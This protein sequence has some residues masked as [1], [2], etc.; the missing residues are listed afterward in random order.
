MKIIADRQ[1]PY[2]QQVFSDL[3]DIIL[4]DGREITSRRLRNADVLL[5][6]SVTRVNADL[7][8]GSRIRFVASA[9]SGIDHVDLEHLEQLQIG[10]AFAPGSNARSVVEYVLSSLFVLASQENILLR[11]KVIGIIGCGQIGS[12]LLESLG[13][14]GIKCLVNDPPLRDKTGDCIYRDLKD[15]MTADIITLHVPLTDR[16]PYPTRRLV[17]ENFLLKMNPRGIL[18]NTSR[19]GVINETSLKQFILSHNDFSVVLDVWENEPD[20][21]YELLASIDI[22]TPHIAGYSTDSKMRATEMIYHQVSRFFN[23]DLERQPSVKLSDVG[24]QELNLADDVNNEDAIQSAVLYHY[25]IRS[26]SAALRRMLDISKDQSACYFDE[27]RRNY[28]VRR[29]FPATTINISSNKHE[30]AQKL[31]RLGF[32][33]NLY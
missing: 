16:G 27:L 18:I 23:L 29:E 22:G 10:F 15:I 7:L 13:A 31:V 30:L 33:V 17:D 1:I 21:D 6:R 2:V 25:D 26:D 20:I 32:K 5:I 19:G 3:G 8:S 9:T 28:P 24:R 14:I 11:D 12:R 4:C